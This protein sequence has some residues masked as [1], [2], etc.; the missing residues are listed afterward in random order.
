LDLVA[1]HTGR[2]DLSGIN[3][4]TSKEKET[5]QQGREVEQTQPQK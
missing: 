4:N 3:T 5:D 1:R 2:P